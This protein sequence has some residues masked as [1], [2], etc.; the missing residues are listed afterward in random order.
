M[1]YLHL[2]EQAKARG[3]RSEPITLQVG[4]RGVLDLPGFENLAGSLS[5]THKDVNDKMRHMSL[6]NRETT[7]HS[8]TLQSVF[9][10]NLCAQYLC[11]ASHECT[12]LR[13]ASLAWPEVT[14]QERLAPRD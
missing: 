4:S 7:Y 2:V 5:L 10:L 13:Q 6:V 3:Y 1:K 11:S 12:A 8:F 14:P 9:F